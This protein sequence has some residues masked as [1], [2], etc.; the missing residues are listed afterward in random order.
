M[1]TTNKRCIWVVE[2]KQPQPKVEGYDV[3][4][5]AQN[6][7]QRVFL[8]SAVPE[9]LLQGNR[10]GGKT[11]ALI[12][13]FGQH[14]GV[15]FGASWNG[16]LF[17]R[18]R[19]Q[20]YD[21]IRKTK[22]LFPQIW[23]GATYNSTGHAWHWPEGESFRL[24]YMERDTDYY[25]YHGHEYPWIGWEELTT[26]PNDHGYRMMMSCWRS[27]HVKVPRKYRATTNPYGPGHNWV[28]HRFHLPI[29]PRQLI[30]E[31]IHEPPSP[32]RTAIRSSLK[33]NK[34]FLAADPEY[35]GKIS[36]AARNPAELKAWL[37]GSWDIVAGGMF[38]DLWD[39]MKHVKPEFIVP[40]SWRIDR[41]FDWGSSSPFSVG[42]WAESD[43]SDVKINGKVYSTVRGDLFR[44]AEWYGWNGRPNEGLKMLAV[45]ISKGIIERELA[46]GIHDRVQPGPADSSIFKVENGVSVGVDMTRPVRINGKKYGGTIWVPSDR[47][48]G[49]RKI[50]WEQMRA[51]MKASVS[52]PGQPREYPGLFVCRNCKDFLRTVPVLPRDLE[53]DPDDAD[54]EAEDH[55][56]DETRYRV[57]FAGIR[58]TGKRVVGL[59]S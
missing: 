14:V 28:K 8:R 30:G 39:P 53:K 32:A 50:G 44:I 2:D 7:S 45:D 10:G 27:S 52:E 3:A 46:W 36:E 58:T 11:E 22:K 4:W 9:V 18:T 24:A 35:L 20:M 21:V 40:H 23:R 54:T 41:A 49:S 5:A 48:S 1:Q 15:G 57:R 19:Q 47:S 6:G 16:I 31:L 33:E 26:W 55:I 12:M 51:M 38:D 25:N 43:G 56:A 59:P 13:D 42:W 34:I 17:R 37:E 29:P